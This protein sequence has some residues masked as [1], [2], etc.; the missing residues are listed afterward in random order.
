[1]KRHVLAFLTLSSAFLALPA[2]AADDGMLASPMASQRSNEQAEQA[3]GVGLGVG[4]RYFGSKSV[5]RAGLLGEAN[6]SNGVFLST[7]DGIG[8]R[9]LNN[10]NGFSMAASIGGSDSRN[11]SDGDSNGRNRLQGMGDVKLRAAANLFVN[12][13]AGL[14]HVNAGLHQTLGER[15]GTSVDLTGRYDVL[16]SKTDLVQVSAGL[17]YANKTEMQTFFGVTPAQSAASGNALYTPGAALAG[18]G[19]GLMWRHAI[20]QNWVTTLD[21]GVTRLG[22]SAADSPLVEHRTTAGVGGSIAYRF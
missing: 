2:F 11:E 10:Y 19:A 7:V 4:N 3:V 13:D 14:F 1:M 6:F 12:Y 16:A 8:Y 5:W 15:R 18:S 9:F 21:A 17:M 20:N 22:A